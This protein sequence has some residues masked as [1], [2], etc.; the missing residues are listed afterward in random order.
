MFIST[1][2][3]HWDNAFS[4]QQDCHTGDNNLCTLLHTSQDATTHATEDKMGDT[5]RSALGRA[6]DT[7]CALDMSL[8]TSTAPTT[9][10]VS[11]RADAVSTTRIA[12]EQFCCST[13][14]IQIIMFH[15]R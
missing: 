6:T 3:I 15:L 1:Q 10:S 11:S 9:T 14:C 8:S 5:H 12:M 2:H 13:H 7:S 4:V